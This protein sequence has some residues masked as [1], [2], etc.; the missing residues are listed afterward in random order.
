[1][2]LCRKVIFE[3]TRGFY[4]HFILRFRYDINEV[5]QENLAHYVQ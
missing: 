4:Y 3:V 2:I 1:M 5:T